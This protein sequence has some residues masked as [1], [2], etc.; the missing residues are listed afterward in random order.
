LGIIECFLFGVG[1]HFL[2][3]RTDGRQMV[4]MVIGRMLFVLAPSL[5]VV[6]EYA[7]KP[8]KRHQCYFLELSLECLFRKHTYIYCIR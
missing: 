4:G 8:Q 7:F 2:P 5:L 1:L 3:G 6:K